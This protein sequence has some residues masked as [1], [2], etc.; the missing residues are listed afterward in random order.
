MSSERCEKC[1]ALPGLITE[2]PF[3]G[4]RH[5]LPYCALCSKDLCRKCLATGTCREA[6][7]VRRSTDHQ[8]QTPYDDS[9]H[10]VE[11]DCGECDGSGKCSCGTGGCRVCSGTGK[12]PTCE[13][14]GTILVLVE[15]GL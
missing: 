4:S 13:G 11:G 8:W 15:E 1:G 12:C 7:T 6:N 5:E 14:T 9:R 2:G 10:R 3:K